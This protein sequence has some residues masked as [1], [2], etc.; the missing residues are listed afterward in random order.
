[1]LS[2][3]RIKYVFIFLAVSVLSGCTPA[4]SS[5]EKVL[6]RGE[7]V[8]L[9]R[10]DPSTYIIDEAGTHGFEYELTSLFAEKLGVNIRFI[11]AKEFQPLVQLSTEDEADFLAAGLSINHNRNKRSH[12]TPPY[13][14]IT[15][16]LVSHYLTRRPKYAANPRGSF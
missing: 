14:E 6:N 13:Y 5:L 10:I 9:T 12:F 15:Q 11:I 2:P 3:S 8:V 7:L 1:M 4:P 16:H